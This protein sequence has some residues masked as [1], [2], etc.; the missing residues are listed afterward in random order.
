MAQ[1]L[2]QAEAGF[3]ITVVDGADFPNEGAKVVFRLLAGE[4]GHAGG[5]GV[6]V[7]LDKVEKQSGCQVG[8]QAGNQ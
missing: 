2:R 5:H 3:K 7:V 4:S 1:A 8:N 6:P